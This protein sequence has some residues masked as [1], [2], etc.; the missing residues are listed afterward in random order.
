MHN[1]ERLQAWRKAKGWTQKRAADEFGAFVGASFSQ[2]M[3]SEWERRG[4]R[5]PK[6]DYA[7]A[8][9]RFTDSEVTAEGWGAV[10]DDEDPAAL[11]PTGTEG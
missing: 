11:R 9:A 1:R 5:R 3:W 7:L 8:L 4:G 10:L 6:L 2:G